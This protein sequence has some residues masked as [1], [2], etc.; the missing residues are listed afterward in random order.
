MVF[1]RAAFLFRKSF[2]ELPPTSH[3]ASSAGFHRGVRVRRRVWQRRPSPGAAWNA[4]ATSSA[5]APAGSSGSA[6]VTAGAGATGAAGATAGAG[7]TSTTGGAAGTGAAGTAGASASAGSSGS[8]GASASAGSSGMAGG[9]AGMGAAGAAPTSDLLAPA[10]GALLGLYYGAGTIAA[11]NTLIGGSLQIHLV[12]Y[13]WS[14]KWEQGAKTD[15]DAG[16]IPLVNWEPDGIDFKNIAN[17][18]LDATIKAR[19]SGAKALGGKLFLDFAAEMNGDEAWSGNDAPLYV[20]AYRHIHD[21]FVAGGATNVLWAWCPNVTD[22]NGGN[23]MTMAYYPG[24]AY[25]DWTGVDGY[26]W[27]GGDW[28]TFEQVFKDIYPLLAA[29]KKPIL[30][31][32]MASAESGG[33]KGAW[34][35]AIIPTLSATYPLFKAVVWF[36]VNKERDWRVNSSAATLTA[37]SKLAQDPY[38]NP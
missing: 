35:D 26:N 12:Y 31:G 11:T 32:E 25:V 19:A 9:A 22:T 33:D 5:G 8:A 17:G 28:Q 24:D 13:A 30:I 14:D 15:L 2:C 38:F 4:G 20:A 36:D 6:G 37:F 10:Q 16:R 27:G 23:K 29:K 21:L 34:I 3:E 18:S 1:A 7:A